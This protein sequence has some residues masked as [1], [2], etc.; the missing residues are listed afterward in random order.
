MLQLRNGSPYAAEILLLADEQGRETLYLVTKMT[1]RYASG[2]LRVGEVQRPIVFADEYHG[3]PARSSLRRMTEAHLLKPGTDV[4]VLG[5]AYAPGGVPTSSC[6]V[7]VRV[8]PMSHELLVFGDRVWTGLRID[9]TASTPSP[10]TVMPI[11]YERAYGG[12]ATAADGS[13]RAEPRNPVGRG[14]LGKGAPVLR[15]P[16]PNIEDPRALV[17]TPASS[18]APVGYGPIA[19]SWAPRNAYVGTYGRTWQETRAPYLTDDFSAEFFH[20]ASPSMRSHR[21]LVG[22]EAVELSNLSPRGRDA[23][24]LPVCAWANTVRLAGA[25]HPVAMRLESVFFEPGDDLVAL[26]WRGALACH[27]RGLLVEEVVVAVDQLQG[28]HE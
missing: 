20:V 8:G 4:L 5:D 10:F 12:S 3:D 24:F 6:R 2:R 11:V 23:F 15:A 9:P 14:F 26:T 13:V 25:V 22:G 17:S 28:V 19:P 16:L 7:S 21:P 27:R 18:P 1:L